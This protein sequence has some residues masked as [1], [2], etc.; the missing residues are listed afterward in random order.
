M[1]IKD[2]LTQD[3]I[4]ALLHG[5]D[6]GEIS[7]ET[8][9]EGPATDLYDF[10]SQDRIVRG[11]LPALDMINDRFARS[12]KASL[13]G[14][15]RRAA[16]ITV[17]PVQM[18]KFGEFVHGM[19]VP[20][21]LNLIKLE[22][23]RG[24]ALVVLD[25]RLVFSVVDSYFGGAGRAHLKAAGQAFTPTENRV[26]SLMLQKAFVDLA[27]AW[28]PVFQVEF[29]ALGAEV[30]PQYANIVNPSDVVVVTRFKI[31]LDDASGDLHL[32]LPYA[33]LEPI[34]ELLDSSLQG[35]RSEQDGRWAQ[36]LREELKAVEVELSSTLS[37][38]KLTLGELSRLKIGDIIPIDL[39]EE[40][41]AKVEGIPVLQAKLGSFQGNYSLKVARW[42][43]QPERR[44]KLIEFLETRKLEHKVGKK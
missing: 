21:S 42:L 4:D 44:T 28:Q 20:T 38:V 13:F 41:S 16:E 9:H 40:V 11:R 27:Q 3:E 5:M 2:L 33:M 6:V 35:E 7:I 14:M 1:S 29:S 37:E 25:S 22:P 32:C 8:E 34:R 24:K 18:L 43:E 39:P 23:L 10:A 12:F 31:D 30:N 17:S 36:A 19:H 15:L 26:I